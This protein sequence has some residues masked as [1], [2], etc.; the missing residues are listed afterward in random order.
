MEIIFD[1]KAIK[2][3]KKLSK[4]ITKQIIDKIENLSKFPNT[5]NI[6]KLTNFYPP[7][8]LKIND[9]RI[10]FD[11]EDNLITIYRIKHRK[12]SYK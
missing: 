8:R 11:I 12:E 7:Y 3:L 4:N 6:K 10:L 5:P 9:Y 2:D 1:D